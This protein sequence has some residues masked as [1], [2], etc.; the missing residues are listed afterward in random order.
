MTPVYPGSP[1]TTLP[2]ILMA[3]PRVLGGWAPR[4]WIP[5][6]ITMVIVSPLS[7]ATFPFQIGLFMVT[8][9]L[10]TGMILQVVGKMSSFSIGGICD[11]SLEGVFFEWFF[12]KDHS[13]KGLFHQQI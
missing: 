3:Y 4:T 7:R 6:S 12:N 13:S 11:R 1:K 5:W 8:N 9:H 10:L 2:P